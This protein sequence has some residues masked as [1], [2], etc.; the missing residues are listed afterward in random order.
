MRE[1]LVLSVVE[2]MNDEGRRMKD[3]D[4]EQLSVINEER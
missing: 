3:K 1:R 2:T 4:S